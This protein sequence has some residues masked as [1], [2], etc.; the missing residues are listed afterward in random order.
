MGNFAHFGIERMKTNKKAVIFLASGVSSFFITVILPIIVVI[1]VLVTPVVAINDFFKS[2]GN[3]FASDND[4]V[5]LINNYLS[6]DDGQKILQERYLP[7]VRNEERIEVPLGYLVLP[8]LL[9]GIDNPT[10]EQLQTQI[11]YMIIVETKE[12]EPENK[13]YEL[14]DINRYIERLRTIEPYQTEFGNITTTTISEYLKAIPVFE[15]YQPLSK[16]YLASIGAD[17][18]IYPF[19]EKA[20]VTSHFGKR[21]NINTS[22]GE[23]GSFHNGTDSTFEYP[24][25]CGM[26]IY[27][28]F[29]GTVI[30]KQ[31]NDWQTT[32]NF[33]HV[34]KDNIVVKYYHMRDHVAY[35]IGHE[36]KKGDYIGVIGTTG[37]STGCHLH[38]GVEIDGKAIDSRE[39]IDWDNPKLP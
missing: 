21:G 11:E 30:A 31:G 18:F 15:M 12:K 39:V 27:A 17:E 32:G 28:V 14:A 7:A 19:T 3:L 20:I 29:D 9:S 33:V 13:H 26:P 22:A 34:Q 8:N 23:T 5:T 4:V 38:L 10:D 16:E 2:I 1:S 36:I 24:N 37:M 25:N 35:P 6:T